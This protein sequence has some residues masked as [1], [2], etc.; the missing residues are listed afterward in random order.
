MLKGENKKKNYL[1]SC[2]NCLGATSNHINHIKKKFNFC[3]FQVEMPQG[4]Q[5][6]QKWFIKPNFSLA[7]INKN[8]KKNKH[9]KH[10]NDVLLRNR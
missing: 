1:V 8:K 5:Q 4:L 10:V 7:R 9:Y 3:S 2:L 6:Q